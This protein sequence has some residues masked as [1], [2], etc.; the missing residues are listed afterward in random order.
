MNKICLNFKESPPIDLN[1]IENKICA[2][3]SN[4]LNVISSQ[5]HKDLLGLSFEESGHTGFASS[6]ELSILSLEVQKI[7]LEVEKKVPKEL[8]VFPQSTLSNR[9]AKIY[10]DNNGTPEQTTIQSIID[11]KMQTVKEIPQ[12]IR[13]GDYIYLEVKE[14][15]RRNA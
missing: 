7:Y 10:L 8:S 11:L 1:I 15:A 6:K 4:E 12:D 3:L 2:N 14:N 5:Q 9:D 13:V